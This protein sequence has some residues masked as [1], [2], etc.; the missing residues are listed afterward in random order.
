MTGKRA[1]RGITLVEVIVVVA[2]TGILMLAAS[3]ALVSGFVYERNRQVSDTARDTRIRTENAVTAILQRAFLP[4]TAADPNL[5]FFI[6]S[7]GPVLE[8]TGS[9]TPDTLTFTTVGRPL[10]A[11]SENPDLTFDQLNED[12]GP[13]GGV[14]EVTLGPNATGGG[15]GQT[16]LFYRRQTPADG[17]P[18]Q[19]GEESLLAADWQNVNFEFWDGQTWV[20][21]WDSRTTTG[22]R[23]PAAIRVNYDDPSGES[24]SFTV[25]IPASD[26]TV[27]SPVTTEGT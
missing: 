11:G 21:Q 1:L 19:G 2:I 20:T 16:G 9:G 8:S 6:A 24:R 18:S 12:F 26:V 7:Q 5:T 14:T 25:R 22:R 13:Q 15:G 17:D 10:A 3:Q 4:L 27:D 23:L